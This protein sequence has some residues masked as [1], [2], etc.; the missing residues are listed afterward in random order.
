MIDPV[1]ENILSSIFIEVFKTGI[2][3]FFK[4]LGLSHKNTFDKGT[5]PIYHWNKTAGFHI[6]MQYGSD[7]DRSSISHEMH[8]FF[9]SLTLNIRLIE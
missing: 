6:H 9:F 7:L 3:G 5:Y 8:Y 1:P 4:T 2:K